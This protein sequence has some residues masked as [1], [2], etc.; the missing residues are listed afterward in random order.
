MILPIWLL[1]FILKKMKKIPQMITV[2]LMTSQ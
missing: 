1:E 2:L